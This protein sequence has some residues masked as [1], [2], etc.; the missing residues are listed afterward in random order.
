[1]TTIEGSCLTW[2]RAT[3][4]SLDPDHCR[5][6]EP[7]RT[8]QDFY[9][10]PLRMT[11]LAPPVAGRVSALPDPARARWLPGAGQG[12]G[13]SDHEAVHRSRPTRI[14]RNRRTAHLPAGSYVFGQPEARLATSILEPKAV[15][16]SGHRPKS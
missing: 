3:P 5:G 4:V 10:F 2:R 8:A 14:W 1:M 9:Q 16:D 11:K 13:H 6:G 7:G 12:S 15:F